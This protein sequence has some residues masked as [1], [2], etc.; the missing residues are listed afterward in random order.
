MTELTTVLDIFYRMG[1]T[2]VESR[3]IDDD[4]HMFGSLNFPERITRLAMITTLS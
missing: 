3:E 1:F 2:A 4:F